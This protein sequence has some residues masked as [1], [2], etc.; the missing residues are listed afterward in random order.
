MAAKVWLSVG[1]NHRRHDTGLQIVADDRLRHP[2]EEVQGP[3][4]PLDPVGQFL[5]EA[6]MGESER[7]R[8]QHGHEDLR[9]ADDAGIGVDDGQCMAGIVGLHHRPRHVTVAECRA[10]PALERAE[11][12]AEPSVAVTV[13][14]GGAIFLPKQRQRHAL[15]LQLTRDH[16]PIRLAQIL[17]RTAHPSE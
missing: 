6:G 11:P 8:A 10:R 15:A 17:R 1:S 5:A 4:L 9:L 12:V 13:G 3:A 2:A 14:M 7:R 16:R